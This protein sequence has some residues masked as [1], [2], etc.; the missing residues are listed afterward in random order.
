ML[1]YTNRKHAFLDI[2]QNIWAKIRQIFLGEKSAICFFVSRNKGA[3][4]AK[5]TP[6]INTMVSCNSLMWTRGEHRLPTKKTANKIVPNSSNWSHL[7][8]ALKY[9]IKSVFLHEQLEVKVLVAMAL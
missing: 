8:N 1:K 5:S 2:Y 3:F 9:C 6:R 7:Q 4:E